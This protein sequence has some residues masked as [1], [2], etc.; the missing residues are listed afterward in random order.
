MFHNCFYEDSEILIGNR[1]NF[2]VSDNISCD[3][4]SIYDII[5]EFNAW[6]VTEDELSS[7]WDEYYYA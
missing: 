1:C 2:H 3:F 6:Y 7:I 4:Y 5:F